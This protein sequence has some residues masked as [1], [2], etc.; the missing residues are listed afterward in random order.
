MQTSRTTAVVETGDGQCPL[1]HEMLVLDA[2]LVR[3]LDERRYR[4]ISRD[5][6]TDLLV[7]LRMEA[8]GDLGIYPAVDDREPG[9]SFI[10]PI[11]TSHFSAHYFANPGGRP[12]VRIDA[13]SCA[14]VDCAA[15][16]AVCHEHLELDDWHACFIE[17]HLDRPQERRVL[18]LGGSGAT[19][20]SVR[21][22]PAAAVAS[23]VRETAASDMPSRHPPRDPSAADP[24]ATRRASAPATSRR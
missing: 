10:Q 6:V 18:E 16:I 22:L 5:L 21:R 7:A 24:A 9:W 1:V 14:S 12:H 11:T 13:Y 17:R 2:W 19:I 8:L 3:R 23:R 15:L 4:R 20:L